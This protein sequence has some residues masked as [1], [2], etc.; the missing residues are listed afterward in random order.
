MTEAFPEIPTNFTLISLVRTGH[1][2]ILSYKGGFKSLNHNS[3]IGS[4]YYDPSVDTG[5]L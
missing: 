3:H 5:P 2:N 4:A 1:V